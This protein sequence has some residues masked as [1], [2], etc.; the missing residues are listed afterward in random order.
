VQDVGP[1]VGGSVAGSTGA[2]G[3]FD[4]QDGGPAIQNVK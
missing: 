4:M 2:D 3:G 1:A